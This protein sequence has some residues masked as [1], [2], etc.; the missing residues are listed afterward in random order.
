MQQVYELIHQVAD[1]DAS[2]L[3]TGESGTGKELVAR[4]LH[5]RSERKR[6]PFVPINCAAIPE[7]LLES[8]LFG[9]ARGAFTGASDDRKGLFEQARAGTV[10]LDE[11]G[12]MRSDMQAKLLRV[13]QEMSVRPVGSTRQVP[14]LAR[15]VAATNV[16]LEAATRRGEFR[17]DLFYRLNVVQIHVP[18]LR[19]RERDVLLLAEHFISASAQRN[20][21][22]ILGLRPAA[23]ESL[24]RYDWPGNVRQ[25]QNWMERAVTLARNRW[26]D[27]PDLPEKV[28]SGP[29]PPLPPKGEPAPLV[30]DLPSLAELEAR[31]VRH[32]LSVAEGNKSRTAQILGISR[33]TLYRKLEQSEVEQS[34]VEQSSSDANAS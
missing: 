19:L 31:Y 15:V 6:Q 26:I 21:K 9:H 24:L 29:P 13:L 11:I 23:A 2:V 1:T 25:L 4:A 30:D 32:V 34:E 28:S 18:P 5:D 22:E 14:L 7:N 12:E 33:K 17:E 10:F 3:V 8:E 27:L 16:D 20:Q